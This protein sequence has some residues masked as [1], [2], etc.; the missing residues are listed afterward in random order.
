MPVETYSYYMNCIKSIQKMKNI[1]LLAVLKEYRSVRTTATQ[2]VHL[3]QQLGSCKPN[4]TQNKKS[5][6]EFNPTETNS[7]QA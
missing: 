3:Q 7:K 2:S 6:Q 4:W 5:L 1:A